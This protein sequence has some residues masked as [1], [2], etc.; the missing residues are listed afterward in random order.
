VDFD[1]ENQVLLPVNPCRACLRPRDLS[2][3]LDESIDYTNEYVPSVKSA[4]PT[5]LEEELDEDLRS[6]HDLA[7]VLVMVMYHSLNTKEAK[8]RSQTSSK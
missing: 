6:F 7:E 4:A 1:K 8:R 5:T 3:A 2:A